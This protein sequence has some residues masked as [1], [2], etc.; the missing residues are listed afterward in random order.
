[1][2]RQD[3]TQNKLPKKCSTLLVLLYERSWLDQ[4]VELTIIIRPILC[5]GELS[6]NSEQSVIG[7]DAD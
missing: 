6:H 5:S 7:H 3:G 4:V 1:M 2:Y